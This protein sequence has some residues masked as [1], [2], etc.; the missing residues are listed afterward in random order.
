MLSTYM[1]APDAALQQVF[2]KTKDQKFM[3]KNMKDS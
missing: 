1:F 2:Y 3:H